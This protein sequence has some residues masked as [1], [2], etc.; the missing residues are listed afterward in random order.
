MPG[1]R[2]VY[3]SFQQG[4]WSLVVKWYE[5]GSRP[6][7]GGFSTVPRVMS[8]AAG[9]AEAKRVPMVMGDEGRRC[10]GLPVACPVPSV[11]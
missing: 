3:N 7:F 6:L 4:P 1:D 8:G 5:G 9:R 11:C 2:G 10:R